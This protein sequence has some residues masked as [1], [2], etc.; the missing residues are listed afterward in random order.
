MRRLN[1]SASWL[2]DVSGP[3]DDEDSPKA[4]KKNSGD[5]RTPLANGAK[6]TS[7]KVNAKYFYLAEMLNESATWIDCD[8][9]ESEKEDTPPPP[10]LPEADFLP[11]QPLWPPGHRPR[12]GRSYSI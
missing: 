1:E 5:T 9:S 10:P 11:S 7:Q 8:F 2:P 12:M 3:S 6:G 4:T